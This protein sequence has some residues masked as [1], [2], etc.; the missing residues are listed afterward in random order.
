MSTPRHIALLTCLWL[1]QLVGARE[2]PPQTV[3][4]YVPYLEWSLEHPNYKGNPFDLVAEATFVH[5]SGARHTTPMFY[6]GDGVWRFRFSGTRLGS[7]RFETTSEVPELSGYTGS[8]TVIAQPDPLL[9]RGFL[10]DRYAPAWAWEN[11]QAFIPRLVMYRTPAF[12]YNQPDKIARDLAL[13][14][15]DHG[16]NGLHVMVFS[17]WF[18][19]NAS[20]GY[21]GSLGAWDDIAGDRNDPNLAPDPRTFEALEQLITAAYAAGGLVH[22]WMWGGGGGASSLKMNLTGFVGGP[23]G[24]I[25]R[26]LQR[27]L[28]AR[29][30]PLPGWTL[31]YGWDI[32]GYASPEQLADW[33]RNLTAQLGWP[34]LVGGR[35]HRNDEPP[36][37]LTD[38]LDYVGHEDHATLN[39][40]GGHGFQRAYERFRAWLAYDPSRPHLSED[41]FRLVTPGW[42]SRSPSRD[43]TP[44]RARRTLWHAAMA[45]GVG[46]IWGQ[47]GAD[48]GW[49]EAGSWPLAN[50]A[51]FRL[52]ADFWDR[53]FRADLTPLDGAGESLMLASRDRSR[54][55]IY[56]EATDT[57]ALDLRSLAAP[58]PAVAVDVAAESY[59]E[60]PLGELAPGTQ[61]WQAPYRSD[62]VIA[63]GL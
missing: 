45:G 44:E 41:R 8:V 58:A 25:D 26:R 29:L 55:I 49:D 43:F 16:F 56:Q 39:Y 17:A 27:Y 37:Q 15:D 24:P 23:G 18:D 22:L 35:A 51:A 6:A 32:W 59:R 61:Q 40:D 30:G 46:T 48:G 5:E 50:R 62:W 57:V 63:V 10:T 2:L 13:W 47:R 38:V 11:G 28:A 54:L 9:A 1:L 31:G 19:I 3:T 42:Q 52:F 7:W 20:E 36:S 34:H 4:Q 12:F 60:L 21:Q 14:F 53:R 33:H